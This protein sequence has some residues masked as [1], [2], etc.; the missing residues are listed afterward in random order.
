MRRM[1]CP[2]C[3]ELVPVQ[4][5]RDNRAILKCGHERT[6]ALLPAKGISLETLNTPDGMRLFPFVL[7]AKR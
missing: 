3:G 6:T 4:T 7:E 1:L 2:E 5:V